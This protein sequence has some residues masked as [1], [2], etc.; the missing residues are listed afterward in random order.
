[1]STLMQF[2]PNAVYNIGQTLAYFA[3][4]I[5]AVAIGKKEIKERHKTI[6]PSTIE[7]TSAKI[8]FLSKN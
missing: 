4:V 8:D 5:V 1:M 2:F 6:R 3:T 7:A